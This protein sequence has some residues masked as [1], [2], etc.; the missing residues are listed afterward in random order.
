LIPSCN[1]SFT[2]E[3]FDYLHKGGRCSG[4]TAMLG[5]MLKIKPIIKVDNGSLIVGSKARGKTKALDK[6]IEDTLLYKD[7]I[8]NNRLFITHTTGS[9]EEAIYVKEILSQHIADMIIHI[10][11]AGCVI[12]SHCGKKTIGI[13][14]IGED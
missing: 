2:I 9:E 8:L 11:Y 5:G 3:A 6:M 7:R 14:F 4:L 10:T 1:S 12:A 13:L